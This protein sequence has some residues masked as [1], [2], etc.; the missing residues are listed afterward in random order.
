MSAPKL[1]KRKEHRHSPGLHAQSTA[2]H[3]ADSL[4]CSKVQFN[5]I[6]MFADDATVKGL[7]SN[8]FKSAY[9]WKVENDVD[10]DPSPNVDK[11]EEVLTLDQSLSPLHLNKTT[12]ERVKIVKHKV[13]KSHLHSQHL[14]RQF[15]AMHPLPTAAL[16]SSP[17]STVIIDSLLCGTGNSVS[18]PRTLKQTI[19]KY[20]NITGGCQYL[21]Q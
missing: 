4:L 8:N 20:E 11:A 7:I 13:E 19:R 9:K 10:N 6:I 3:I 21:I 14:P 15:W 5:S 17:P 2:V 12:V 18:D 1:H 16:T